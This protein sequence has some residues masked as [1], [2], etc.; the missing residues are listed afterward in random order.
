MKKALIHKGS[1]LPVLMTCSGLE[2]LTP[3]LS[4]WVIG[5]GVVCYSGINPW[6]IRVFAVRIVF[7]FIFLGCLLTDFVNSS[8]T[9]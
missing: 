5:F 7:D 2:P 6:Y 4:M 1:R 3:T 9:T 8:S